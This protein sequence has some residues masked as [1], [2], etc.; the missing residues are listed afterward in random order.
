[1]AKYN[2]ETL[3]LYKALAQ[4]ELQEVERVRDLYFKKHPNPAE[5][6]TCQYIFNSVIEEKKTELAQREIFD[7]IR[8]VK[9]APDGAATPSQGKETHQPL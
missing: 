3:T 6:P 5:N 2:N 8:K 9:S 7:L 4:M 1:M